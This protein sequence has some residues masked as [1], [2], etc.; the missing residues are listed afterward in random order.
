MRDPQSIAIA[1][2]PRQTPA[3]SCLFAA[4]AVAACSSDTSVPV[5]P[6][7][8]PLGAGHC[9]TPWP[10]S[11]FEVDD[12]SSLT[13]RRLAIP[14][15]TLPTNSDDVATDPAGWNVADG[16]SPAAPMVMSWKGGVS[17]D[18]LAAARQPRSLARGRQPDG[19][20]RHD[21]RSARRALRRARCP[22]RRSTRLAGGVPAAGRA[23]DR[24]SSLRGRD[25]QP[26]ARPGR[27]RARGA[28]GVRRA[29][30]STRTPITR[31]SR[32]C[33][34]G[35][36]RCSTR[37]TPPGSR[38]SD[39][40]VAWDFT[41]A[42][43]ELIHRDMIAARDRALAAL[44]GHPI[45]FT[46]ASD[47]P[48]DDGK[49]IQRKITG[50]LDAPLFLTRG[51]AASPGTDDRARRRRPAGAAGLLPDPVHRDRPGV[52]VHREG[53]GR[54]WCCTATACSAAPARP[55]AA[56]S[57]PPRPSCAPCSSAPICA[58][59]RWSISR[60]SRARS[61]TS[62]GPTRSWR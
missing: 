25:H 32:R 60:R 53:P 40:V 30:R 34:R 14:E 18:G 27:L 9:M 36:A 20:H 29:A 52:R 35:S 47:A 51:G 15:G 41:V 45:G 16:F 12:A 54:R 31:C 37:S 19:D 4:L 2:A 56:R 5:E 7:C 17:P 39:L 33:A 11:A 55:P 57:R 3:A 44:A 50:T 38:A 8:N 22:G 43:D 24:W 49:V 21:D 59:C 28:A 26:R 1:L 61:T 58:A 6:Q 42:S 23:A 10:S 46:I 62:P 48:I 13:G